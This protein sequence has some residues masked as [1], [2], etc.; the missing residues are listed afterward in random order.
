M[1]ILSTCLILSLS[2]LSFKWE[3]NFNYDQKNSVVQQPTYLNKNVSYL[4]KNGKY[5]LSDRSG[6]VITQPQYDYS[7][8][9]VETGVAIAT[10]NKKIG[11]IN[12]SGKEI[13]PFDYDQDLGYS[14]GL[15]LMRKKIGNTIGLY[16]THFIDKT[17]KIVLSDANKEYK[18]DGPF[19]SGRALVKAGGQYGYI[20][21]T[22]KI[23][24]PI[25]YISFAYMGLTTSNWF[26]NN[27]AIVTHK[28]KTY[29][30]IDVNGKDITK[31]TY[32]YIKDNTSMF[33]NND[34]IIEDKFFIYQVN[35]LENFGYLDK[36]GNEI[37][38]PIY[39][40]AF[41]MVEGMGKVIGEDF[42]QGFV[43]KTGKVAIPLIYQAVNDFSDGLAGARKDNK[44]G[45]IDK[46]GKTIIPFLYESVGKFSE[47]LAMAKLNGKS[48]FINKKGEWV[49]NPIYDSTSGYFK[50]GLAG[51]LVNKLWGFINKSGKIVIEP[52]YS[53]YGST[54]FKDG[55]KA[56]DIGN[57][58]FIYIDTN[59]KEFKEQ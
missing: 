29:S 16:E 11:L 58:K 2:I 53:I 49:I 3:S 40:S 8:N 38:P 30:I 18:I 7:L 47:G 36:Y 21:K 33:S 20:D 57:Y 43:N 50:E 24:I 17:G 1:K 4:G 28:D 37:T 14:E 34:E 23:V 48:G 32:F 12:N 9:F 19:Y 13:T 31:K 59:G 27:F 55:L 15:F 10:K 46:T 39:K 26:N 35:N 42:K 45:F 51:V 22:G 41:P 5:G 56:I 6:K 52:K 25:K 54:D 44:W